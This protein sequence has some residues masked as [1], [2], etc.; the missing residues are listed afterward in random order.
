M[1]ADS[2]FFTEWHCGFSL[3]EVIVARR[4]A[5]RRRQIA[6]A[7]AHMEELYG[8]DCGPAAPLVRNINQALAIADQR[9]S[10]AEPI[11][12]HTRR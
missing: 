10:R 2:A 11:L 3:A 12:Q 7:S 1:N 8:T 5:A 4:Q 6:T 9:F